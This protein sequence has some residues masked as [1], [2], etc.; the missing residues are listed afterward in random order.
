[1]HSVWRM[2]LAIGCVTCVM[3]TVGCR[4]NG[5]RPHEDMI[6]PDVIEGDYALS[7]RADGGGQIVDV[8]FDN[9]LFGYDSSQIP[10]SELFKIERVADY[11][12]MKTSVRLVVEGHCDERGSRGYNMSLGEQRALAIRNYLISL[13]VH[14]RRVQTK[15]YG[16]EK[17]VSPEHD[18]LAWSQNRRGDFMLYQ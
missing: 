17:P 16:E 1:M 9:V 15:S 3:G 7:A 18:E 6:Y 12:R 8:T 14:S 13:G 11:L 2:I 5:S 10:R 4:T